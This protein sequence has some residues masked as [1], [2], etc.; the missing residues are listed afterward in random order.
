MNPNLKYNYNTTRSLTKWSG[1]IKVL[2]ETNCNIFV[3]IKISRTCIP[4]NI[5]SIN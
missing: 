2:Q 4:N 5:M 1:M 3:N